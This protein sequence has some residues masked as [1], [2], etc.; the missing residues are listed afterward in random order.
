MSLWF[1]GLR[2]LAA[3][4]MTVRIAGRCDKPGTW[5]VIVRARS[6]RGNL[7]KF[8]TAEIHGCTRNDGTAGYSGWR[9]CP[10]MMIFSPL[11]GQA[12]SNVLKG[13]G[14]GLMCGL[15]R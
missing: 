13:S 7:S 14:W 11:I 6:A 2:F 4:G 5:T 8:L 9:C 1:Q 10:D 3:L 12:I 15:L